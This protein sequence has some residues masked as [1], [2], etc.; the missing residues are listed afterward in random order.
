MLYVGENTFHYGDKSIK[1]SGKTLLFFHPQ[2]SYSYDM[3]SDDTTGFFCVFKD[4]FYKENFRL[5]LNDL[6]LFAPGFIPVYS[7][8]GGRVYRSRFNFSKD[9]QGNRYIVRI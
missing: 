8:S 1:V 5:N 7:L 3:V 4:E 9:V 2:M 6:P